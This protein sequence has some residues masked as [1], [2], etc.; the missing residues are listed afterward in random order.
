[1]A[2]I[3][4]IF[5]SFAPVGLE[6]YVEYFRNTFENFIYLKWKF[7][8]SRGSRS[9]L[10]QYKKGKIILEKSLLSLPTFHQ[11]KLYFLFLP[12][13][14]LVYLYQALTLFRSR[15]SNLIIF[16]GVN[17]FCTFCGILLKK[18]H[19]VDFV[20]YRVMDFFP[21]PPKGIY[22][23]L[24]R[25]F[26]VIDNYCLSNSDYIWFTTEGHIIGRERYGYFD[27]NKYKDKYLIIPL[28]INTKKFVFKPVSQ[29]NRYSL[30]YCGVISRYHML[31]LLF[32][33]IRE[34]KNDFPNIKLN[35]IGSGPDEMYFKALSKEMDLEKNILFHGFLE[36]GDFLTSI[37]V[38]NILGIALYRDE[39]NYMKYTEPA[40][41]KYYLMFGLPVVVSKVP[42]IAMELNEKKVCFAVNNDKEEVVHLIKRFIQ[43]IDLQEEYLTNICNYVKTVDINKLLETALRKTLRT[44][45]NRHPR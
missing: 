8:H 28:G 12:L 16:M 39:E 44:L 33:V 10:I 23:Y 14:Y 37:M 21:L 6:D 7:P 11:K 45:L 1:M 27:R 31:D 43:D 24:N 20:I 3:Q 29:R 5:C 35:I 19:K 17:Y 32:E 38:D 9:S 26:Y 40:K 4:F 25:I 34:L 2:K 15:R 18:L 42:P 30:V 13:H 22:R 36:E 41:V